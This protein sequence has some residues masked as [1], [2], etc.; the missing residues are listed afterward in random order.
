[1]R[2]RINALGGVAF[3]A[4]TMF[5]QTRTPDTFTVNVPATSNPYLAGLP[6]G[7]KARMGDVAPQ[8]SPVLVERT[9]FNAVAVTF[10]AVGAV[11]HT[12]DCP[13]DCVGPNGAE[14]TSHRDGAEH[15]ISNVIAPMNGLVG[16]FLSD[17]RP[18]RN[19]APRP[20]DRQARRQEDQILSPKLKQ[21][22]FIGD[23]T[24]VDGALRRYLVPAKA[25]RL[26]LGVMDSYEWNNNTGSFTATVAIERD[27][28]DSSM[29][30]VDSIITY[31]KWACIP[32]RDRC[33]PD[34]AVAEEKNPG[35][36]HVIL[37]ATAEWG[38]SVPVGNGAAI[39]HN[40]EGTVCLSQR[41]CY[42]PQG[43]GKSAGPSFLAEDKPI[44]A[45]LSRVVE[46][47]IYFSVNHRKGMPFR[48]HEGYFDFYV[49]T[50]P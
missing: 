35:H 1:M 24:T 2:R 41:L 34:R 44:G 45:L 26:Y 31:S 49:T 33:T 39:I 11:Q 7:T 40:A 9:L 30:S 10:T 23:G 38:I 22:F 8:H 48:D 25:S 18:D 43:E 12:P 13:P 46:G 3:V 47:R 16:V 14:L 5:S 6:A 20:I 17:V 50:R 28:V 42:G 37:P 21:V 4:T 27:R 32:D 19:D 36:F 29:L 15:G